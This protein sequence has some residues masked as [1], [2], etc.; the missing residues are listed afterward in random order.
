MNTKQLWRDRQTALLVARGRL[1]LQLANLRKELADVDRQIE[2]LDLTVS[3]LPDASE[4]G[5]PET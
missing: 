2:A 5:T 4:G 3:L 1:S